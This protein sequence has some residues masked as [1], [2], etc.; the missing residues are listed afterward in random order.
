[1]SRKSV[2]WI[3]VLCSLVFVLA[4]LAG[5]RAKD[6][7]VVTPPASDEIAE[8]ESRFGPYWPLTGLETESGQTILGRTLSVKID[9]HPQSGSKV[10]INSAD[11]VFESLT[12]GGITRFNAIYQSD[13]PE[14]VMP[15]RSARESDTYIIPQFGNALFF[16]SGANGSV[17]QSLRDSDVVSMSHGI[18]GSD[19]YARSSDRSAPHNLFV[20]L[21]MAYDIAAGRDI[22]VET[23]AAITGL[24]FSNT[25]F[26]DLTP[27]Q[28]SSAATEVHIP[29]SALS[30]TRWTWDDEEELWIRNSNG[31]PQYDGATDEKI[32][33]DNVVVMWASHAEGFR[34]S[35]GAVTLDV[36]LLSGGEV[37]VFTNGERFDGVWEGSV[38]APPVF[39]DAAGNSILLSPGR[40]WINVVPLDQE[41]TSSADLPI[42]STGY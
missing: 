30:D 11:V 5:C 41:I 39:K 3:A 26:D 21:D 38:D 27:S 7:V 6:P 37:S 15:V 24:Q 19:L 10:G 12:E 8:E 17:L 32:S 14:M 29:F 9:N 2:L 18:I 34:T 25:A 20:E 23:E 13:I 31:S 36:D 35:R 22:E 16:Y 1:M 42:E 4:G 28:E 33:A 40:T